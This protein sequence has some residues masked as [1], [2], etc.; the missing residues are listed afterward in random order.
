M[1]TPYYHIDPEHSGELGREA[2]ILGP[3]GTG[4]ST[5][6]TGSIRNTALLRGNDNVVAT[7]FTTAAAAELVSRGLP[8]PKSQVGTLHSLAY[9]ELDRPPIADEQIDDWNTHHPA[10]ALSR[11]G[12]KANV[13]DGAPVEAGNGGATEGD[14]LASTYDS[15]RNRLLP[16]EEWPTDVRAFA[17]KW[18]DWKRANGLIDFGDMIEM[19]YSDVL[20]APGHPDVLFADE[21]QDF[22]PL[23]LALVRKWGQRAERLVLAGDP[24]QCHP[25][26]EL[27]RTVNRGDVPIEDLTEG[28]TLVSFD[29]RG[30]SEIRRRGYEWERGCRPYD[31]HLLAISTPNGQTRV[32][33]N[34]RLVARWATAGVCKVV[35]LMRSGD[36]WRLGTSDLIRRNA[37]GNHFGPGLRARQEGADALWIL[38]VHRSDAEAQL[39]EDRA[40]TEYGI[41]TMVFRVPISGVLMQHTQDEIDAHHDA[42]AKYARPEAALRDHGRLPDYPFWMPDRRQRGAKALLEVAACNYLPEVMAVPID[43]GARCLSWERAEVRR[44]R[45]T[46]FVYSLQVEPYEHY[47]AGGIVVHNS[48]YGFKGANPENWLGQPVDDSDKIVLS[49][50]WRIPASVHRAAEHWIRQ[51]SSYLEMRYDPRDEEGL[52]RH[53]PVAYNTPMGLLRHIGKSLETEVPDGNGGTRPA[54]V[55]VLASCGY[56]LDP[57]K[58]EMR[59]AGI[60]FHNPYRRCSPPDEPVLT[61]QGYVA[62]GD[63]DPA[64]HRLAGFRANTNAMSWG[65]R[66]SDDL[67]ASRPS[68][69]AAAGATRRGFAFSVGARPYAGRML[70]LTTARSRTRVTPNHRVRVRYADA[71]YGRWMVYLMRRGDDWRIGMTTTGTRPFVNGSASSRLTR[72]GG[73]G[74]WVL[75]THATRAEAT[76]AEAFAQTHY[77]IS[78]MTFAHHPGKGVWAQEQIDAH[79]AALRPESTKRAQLLLDA[80]GL[81]MEHPLFRRDRSRRTGFAFE[82]VAANVIDGLMEMPVPPA[83]WEDAANASRAQPDWE[84]VNVSSEWYEGDVYSLD[85][86]GPEHYVSGGAVVHNSRGDWNPMRTGGTGVSSRERLLAYLTLDER[87]DTGLGVDARPWTG[88]DV[89]R[90][91]HVIKKRGIFVRGA[92]ARLEDLPAGELAYDELA[93][94]FADDVELEQ[95]VTPDLRWFERNLLAASR[96]GMA[97]PIEVARKRGARALVEEPRVVLGTIHSVKGGAADIVYV[98][99]DLSS[100]G[101]NEWRQRGAPQDGVRR[102]FYV[103]MTRAR[104]E[105]VVCTPGTT[106]FVSPEQLVAGAR[107]QS[108]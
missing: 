94:L 73:D 48:I 106:M 26:G 17:T 19:A 101:S 56:M 51:Q 54:T 105:L 62:I 99:P 27:V 38:S 82:T 43:G 87:E 37:G 39:A 66:W 1:S 84:L 20:H 93:A 91:A 59:K 86:P 12:R 72:E 78:G 30:G 2:W 31:G 42:V 79:H 10:Y 55:M 28:D 44:D 16:R 69:P 45:Y 108:A 70:T 80:Y 4:K 49:Q 96:Q 9:R 8:L 47:V 57:I 92:D 85:V 50:S 52:V 90:W 81:E 6:L 97:F 7:S 41:S 65:P 74:L 75:S 76:L 107:L 60:P 29:K 67:S 102:L 53:A 32:T 40:S 3:P 46:G 23:E 22:T 83:G 104:H 35:Y 88:D 5:F 63:L 64:R 98:V 14:A 34:H 21:V 61:D 33:P 58:H 24:H 13:D 100:R 77:G 89:R 36:R 18:E 68:G 15:F 11:T 71:W 95:A 25:P 103:A